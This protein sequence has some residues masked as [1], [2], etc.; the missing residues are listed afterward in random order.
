VSLRVE[1]H[2]SCDCRGG[3]K[4]RSRQGVAQSA[5]AIIGSQVNG[6]ITSW[7]HGAQRLFGYTARE[8]IGRNVSRLVSPVGEAKIIDRLRSGQRVERL[9]TQGLHKDGSL[10]DIAL[11]CSLVRNGA[12][13]P[14]GVLMVGHDFSERARLE[15][16]LREREAGLRRA[17]TVAQLAHVITRGDGSFE[18]WFETLPQL[19]GRPASQLPRATREWLGI[20]HADDR[21]TFRAK[22]IEAAFSGHRTE[23]QY[24]LQ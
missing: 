19:I 16:A 9:Q 21:A 12:G 10:V 14:A 15:G 22:S 1:N 4:R 24:R 17:Q 23:L 6:T 11:S 2:S 13:E 18:S 5:D 7:N 20:V 3:V 8:A